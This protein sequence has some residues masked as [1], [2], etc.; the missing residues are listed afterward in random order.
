MDE[1]RLISQLNESWKRGKRKPGRGDLKV[2]SGPMHQVVFDPNGWRTF[3]PGQR[4]DFG[5]NAI[6]GNAGGN[7]MNRLLNAT[8]RIREICPIKM[9]DPHD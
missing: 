7:L 2:Q 1:V 6:G 8:D 4:K 9:E 3:F 5:L